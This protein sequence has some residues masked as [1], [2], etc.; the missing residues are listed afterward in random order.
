M[1]KVS[2]C[3]PTYQNREEVERLLESIML[4]SYKDYEIIITDD[5]K[6]RETEDYISSLREKDYWIKDKLRYYHNPIPLGHIYNWN[7]ALSYAT[8]EYI[9]IMFSDDWMIEKECLEKLV[10]A[11]DQNMEADF[12][13][14]KNFQ[15][16]S[17]KQYER[18]P[19]PGYIEKLREDY[20]YL[21]I[22]NQIG[23]PSNTMY[24]RSS[25]VCFDESSNWASD[26]FL[27][28]EILRKNP[29][30]VYVDCPL[31]AI[32]IHENQYTE[33]FS[34]EDERI[35]N[36]YLYM[37]Q[38]YRLEEDNIYRNYLLE[39]YLVKSKEGWVLAKEAGYSKKEFIQGKYK[40]LKNRIIP[41][42]LY[43]I[44][45]RLLRAEQS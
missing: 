20:R 23:A 5:S 9:K 26:V 18:E 35:I 25:E 36:D 27:Y 19:E 38:K 1:P 42:Y 13:F 14:C 34:E 43:A 31:I 8:G 16:S 21:F 10:A 12:V 6:D 45:R 15:V 37:F 22:S 4:Q 28:L 11:L 39:T 29:R 17:N 44:K 32:G 33:S 41:S 40:D 2:I 30:F 3:I 7:K 24:R